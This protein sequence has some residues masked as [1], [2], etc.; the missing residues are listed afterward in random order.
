MFIR[1]GGGSPCDGPGGNPGGSP[2]GG[3]AS[4]RLCGALSILH[5]ILRLPFPLKILC[6]PGLH[7]SRVLYSDSLFFFSAPQG[8][9]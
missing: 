8:N 5:I 1:I 9:C 7:C 2:G 6:S 3:P 4:A